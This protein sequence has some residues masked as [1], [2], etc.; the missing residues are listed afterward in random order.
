MYLYKIGTNTGV[1]GNNEH[2]VVLGHPDKLTKEQLGG[3]V[4]TAIRSA[5]E[6]ALENS[7]A[8]EQWWLHSEQPTFGGLYPDIVHALEQQGFNMVHF[9]GEWIGDSEISLLCTPGT[10]N[11]R[12]DPPEKLDILFAVTPDL[13]QRLQDTRIQLMAKNG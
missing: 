1:Q 6:Q 4:Q 13:R 7:D 8:P 12:H 2:Y 5:L 11:P 10:Y 9:N 3:H